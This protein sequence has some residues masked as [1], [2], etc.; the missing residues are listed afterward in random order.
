MMTMAAAAHMAVTLAMTALHLDHGI[1]GVGGERACR[2][3][4]HGR[5]RRREGGERHGDKACFDKTFHW[6]LL[7][8]R[9]RQ[10]AQVPGYIFV[11]PGHSVSVSAPTAARFSKDKSILPFFP[12]S[13]AA[14]GNST[15]QCRI[16]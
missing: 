15:G 7:H 8:R 13:F 6:D 10:L 11:P 9:S 16:I 12:D 3:T 14:I 1:A 4:R 5:C 2:N